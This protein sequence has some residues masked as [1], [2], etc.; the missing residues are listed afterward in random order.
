[1]QLCRKAGIVQIETRAEQGILPDQPVPPPQARDMGADVS[2]RKRGLGIEKTKANSLTYSGH[3]LQDR[4][5]FQGMD[6]SVENKKGSTREGIDEDGQPWKTTFKYP[7]GYIRGTVGV[8][9]DHVDCY[10]GPNEEAKDAFIIH[11]NV[12]ETGKYD[13][14]KVMLG[15]NSKEDAKKAYEEHYNKDGFFGSMKV[16]SVD[17]LKK[18]LQ[19]RKGK[20]L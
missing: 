15:F 1:M 6:I 13:E 17:K 12:P 9:K 10:I 11:Q 14:D 5:K 16:V 4:M 8:D 2:T 18:L 3:K 19:K 7:Y 20:K